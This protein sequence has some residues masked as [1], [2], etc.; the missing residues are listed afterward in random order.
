MAHFAKLDDFNKVLAVH[1]VNNDVITVDGVESEQEGINFLTNLHGHTKWKQT[2]YS[3]A[4]RKNFAGIGY[5]YDEAYDF[6][7]APKPYESWTLNTTTG[8]WESP[9]PRPS[10]E[11]KIFVWFEPN[12]QWIEINQAAGA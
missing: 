9:V 12:Q 2:S 5:T 8:Q 11:G 7:Y 10:E 4:I 6:F 1:V 3:G